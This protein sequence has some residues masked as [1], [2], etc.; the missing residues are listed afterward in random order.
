MMPNNYAHTSMS[1]EDMNHE[2]NRYLFSPTHEKDFKLN[3]LTVLHCFP[4]PAKTGTVLS[5]IIISNS[6]HIYTLNASDT[7]NVS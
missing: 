1:R 7:L 3:S 6:S 4:S 2:R 5:C